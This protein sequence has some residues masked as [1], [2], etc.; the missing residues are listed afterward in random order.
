MKI[1]DAHILLSKRQIK[2]YILYHQL[3]NF[4]IRK[5]GITTSHDSKE[6]MKDKIKL[7][8]KTAKL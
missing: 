1:L 8:E 2:V 3:A 7:R 6:Y 4:S 5:T